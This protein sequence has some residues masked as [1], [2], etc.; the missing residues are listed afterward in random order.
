MMGVDTREYVPGPETD[1]EGLA[2]APH[3]IRNPTYGM[4]PSQQADYTMDLYAMTQAG[5]TETNTFDNLMRYL[6]Q[7]GDPTLTSEV[8]GEVARIISIDPGM[9]TKGPNADTTLYALGVL[10]NTEVENAE[11]EITFP[12]RDIFYAVQNLGGDTTP[13][14]PP[15]GGTAGGG[16][17]G[18]AVDTL[19]VGPAYSTGYS[20]G[21]ENLSESEIINKDLVDQIV[22]GQA[23]YGSDFEWGTGVSGVVGDIGAGAG[24]GAAG[25]GKAAWGAM[26]G[27]SYT[28][29]SG[30]EYGSTQLEQIANSAIPPGYTVQQWIEFY[31]E[32]GKKWGLKSD[33]R[34]GWE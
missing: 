15:G 24:K 20:T 6:G 18:D 28:S 34:F 2:L 17:A 29:S 19:D 12:Y 10:A 11:G 4:T 9:M 5:A 25:A 27:D 26:Q 30:T 22:E 7:T 21:A 33:G 31:E 3:E 14:P 23:G 1:A 16:T 13:P 32:R 8:L